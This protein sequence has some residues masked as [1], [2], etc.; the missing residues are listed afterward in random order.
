MRVVIAED[1]TLL[2]EG[3]E[4]VL[5]QGGFDVL[6]SVG[7]GADVLRET[8]AHRP[9]LAILDLRMPPSHSDE[10]L[11]A[12]LEIRR[13]APGTA[14]VLLSH[15]LVRRC[16]IEL[17]TG[18]TA[19]VG[20]LLKQRIADTATFCVDLR[21]V[22]AGGTVLDPEIVSLVIRRAR[23]AP[24]GVERLTPRQREVLSLMAEG[25]SNA[26]IAKALC[27]TERAIVQHVSNIY[28][29][30]GLP[31]SDDDHRRVLAVTRYLAR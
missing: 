1:E 6:A 22:C 24:A 14:V 30:L 15:Y 25:R 23:G 28:D 17:L 29:V 19:G 2:R 8:F 3:L 31:A 12:A 20:Y 11:R 7:D 26:A 18:Q 9:D 21:R 27:V 4:L 16:A 10:G 13:A 5:A